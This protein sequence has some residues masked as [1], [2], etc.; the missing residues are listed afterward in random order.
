VR[1]KLNFYILF[2][3]NSVFKGLMYLRPLPHVSKMEGFEA[4]FSNTR[5]EVAG[6]LSL[7]TARSS[8]RM[9]IVN[10]GH[11]SPRDT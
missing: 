5:H 7:L 11:P 6:K 2:R 1:Y 4:L 8:G 3:I 10:V 9:I